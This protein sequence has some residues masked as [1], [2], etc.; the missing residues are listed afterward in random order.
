M[1][2]IVLVWC[3]LALVIAP[4]FA[5]IAY[6]QTVP[7]PPPVIDVH[8]HSTNTSPAQALERMTSLNIRYLFVS[9]LAADLPT[10]ATA[11][12]AT[13][14]IPALVLPCDGGR[15]PI[16][17]RPCWDGAGNFPDVTWLRGELKAGRIKALGEVSPQYLG[18]APNDPRLEP[19]WQLAE[20]FD[21]PIGIH[22]GPG[23]AGAAYDSSPVPFK[24]PAFSMAA[25]DPLLLEEV[26][27]HHKRLRLFVMHAGWP[28]LDSMLALLYSNPNVYVDIAALQATY[29][30]PRAGYVRYLQELVESGFAK[31]IMF[32]SDFSDQVGPGIDAILAA[33]FLSVDQKADILCRN[34]ARFLR[35]DAAICN[36]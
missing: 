35:L 6:S 26:L 33:D 14:F 21:I 36:P 22:M 3:V 12:D 20:E 29:I 30:V 28:R 17:G 15:A 32:G 18:M 5:S 1:V 34:A 7:S 16:T 4:M 8:V 27:L 31:R 2:R 23:P 19:Y 11:L 9:S 10:W 25:G 13:K 24:S